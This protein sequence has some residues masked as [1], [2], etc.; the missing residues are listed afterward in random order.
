[1]GTRIPKVSYEVFCSELRRIWRIWSSDLAWSSK[2]PESSGVLQSSEI[3]VDLSG[4]EEPGAKDAELGKPSFDLESSLPKLWTHYEELCLW[5]PRLSLIGPGTSEDVFVR[6][7]VESLIGSLFLTGTERR[8]V[9]IGSGGGFPGLI[10][11][12]AWPRL[13]CVLVEPREK[14]WAFL[15]SVI[16]KADLLSCHVLNARVEVPLS[17]TFE[18]SEIIDVVTSRALSLP[19]D[20]LAELLMTFPGVKLLLWVGK[21]GVSLPPVAHVRRAVTMP[22]SDHRQIIEVVAK[23]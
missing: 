11:S 7:Y 23:E 14:K 20:L 5:N 13:E 2:M 10:L 1:M 8:L 22:D 12:S 6:H 9:D 4:S 17:Q 18:D 3:A 21:E 15:R 19:Q 16:R